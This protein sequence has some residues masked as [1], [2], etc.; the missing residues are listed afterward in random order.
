MIRYREVNLD[1]DVRS[2]YFFQR[3]LTLFFCLLLA[4][5]VHLSAAEYATT[6]FVVTADSSEFAKKVALTAESSRQRLALL[7]L[8]VELPPWTSPC[9]IKVKVGEKLGAGGE[10]SFTFKG[11]EVF[12]WKMKIQ[13]TPERIIDSVIP[14]EI[15]HMILASY[16]RQPVPRWI[17]EGAATT[18]EAHVERANY[19]QMLI[20]FLNTSKGIPFNRMVNSTEYPDD[21]LPFYAQG[22]S[23]CE[24]LIAIGGHR[25]LVEFA[26]DGLTS[27]DWSGALNRFYKIRDINEFQ[28]QWNAWISNWY[29]QG[30]PANLPV[31]AK[32]E[33]YPYDI[34][35]QRIRSG[36][37]GTV[38]ASAAELEQAIPG[39]ASDHKVGQIRGQEQSEVSVA[40]NT[41]SPLK[42]TARNSETNL[43]AALVY[44]GSYGHSQGN[45]GK[46]GNAVFF[47]ESGKARPSGQIR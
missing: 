26:R 27:G 45:A 6:N 5:G 37:V 15:S 42:E 13:G 4:S 24:Y 35:G 18:V 29:H 33:D 36:A 8:G 44:Q 25:R 34:T 41:P 7:W 10:T 20:D 12:G 11:N 40:Q 31:V 19:R 47:S 38:I 28:T 30:M 2:E 3:C 23:V 1:M 32:I 16:F 39:L 17:D 14:H 9:P 21:I 22:F 46:L 43:S